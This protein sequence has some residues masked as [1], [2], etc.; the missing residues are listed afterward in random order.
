MPLCE[1]WEGSKCD[2]GTRKGKMERS[3]KC[4]YHNS[5]HPT[6]TSI[7][8]FFL[9]LEKTKGILSR[10]KQPWLSELSSSQKQ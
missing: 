7:K 9:L 2:G 6:I 10:I 5:Q 1:E 8:E 4:L 3:D